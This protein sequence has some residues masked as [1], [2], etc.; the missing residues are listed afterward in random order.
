MNR[1]VAVSSSIVRCRHSVNLRCTVAAA[2]GAHPAPA[3]P[4]LSAHCAALPAAALEEEEEEDEE[5]EE[6]AG[7]FAAASISSPDST[8]FIALS[9]RF[10]CSCSRLR[11]MR[12]WLSSNSVL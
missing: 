2:R 6:E 9:S 10:P 1:S 8:L 7:A 4:E 11:S 5:E 3:D 12:P